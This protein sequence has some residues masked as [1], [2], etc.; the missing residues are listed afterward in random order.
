MHLQHE[1]ENYMR[2]QLPR[3]LNL[4]QSKQVACE[5]IFYHFSD[6]AKELAEKSPD[7]FRYFFDN[8]KDRIDR[9]STSRSPQ[10]AQAGKQ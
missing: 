8:L 4:S 1:F 3:K 5:T 7:E 9:I 10:K 2:I 6:Y